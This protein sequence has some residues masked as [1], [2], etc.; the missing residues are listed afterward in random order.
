MVGVCLLFF[1]K[2]FYSIHTSDLH[3][4]ILTTHLWQYFN[5]F[6]FHSFQFNIAIQD[7]PDVLLEAKRV[8]APVSG[9]SVTTKLPLCVEISLETVEGDKMT[10]ELWSLSIFD[11]Q[12]D[13]TFKANYAVSF[14]FHFIFFT[15][16]LI[17][18]LLSDL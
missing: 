3:H 8:L 1:K 17:F 5:E 18:Y 16:F 4:I 2:I 13:P 15:K 6:F 11:D 9:E 12:N 10:L 14:F 7:Q